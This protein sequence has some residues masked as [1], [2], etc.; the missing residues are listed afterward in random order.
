MKVMT[1]GAACS[2]CA[3]QFIK[4]L[5]AKEHTDH[6]ERAVESILKHHYVDNFVD[7]F[8]NK[9]EAIEVAQQV[10]EIH[11][12][13]G[14][15]LRNLA[16]NSE[17][18][19][20][21]LCG[22]DA[23]VPILSVLGTRLMQTL[24]EEHS[25]KASNCIL[26]SDSKTVVKWMRIE[27]RRYKPFVAHRVAEILA[28]TTPSNWR[29]VPTKEN[30]ADE[31]T[32]P[33]GPHEYTAALRGLCGPKS[34][35]RDEALW[36]QE[37]VI[38][39]QHLKE[40]EELNPRYSLVIMSIDINRFSS[41]N[42]LRRTVAWALRFGLTSLKLDSA[43]KL[44]LR[45]TQQE[46]FQ[47][48]LQNIAKGIPISRTS[49]LYQLSL[50][51]DKDGV[52]RVQGRIDAASSLPFETRHP[53]ILPSRHALTKLL[54]AYH[55]NSF[56]HENTE[57]TICEI[58]HSYWIPSLCQLLRNIIANSFVCRI[59]KATPA[60]PLDR[61]D[62][63]VRPFTY[64][65]LDYFG[66]VAVTIGRRHEKRWV[67]LFTC[68]TVRAVHLE[69]AHDLSTDSCIIAI[70]NFINRRGVPAKIRSDNGKNFVGANEEAKRFAEV[71]DCEQIQVLV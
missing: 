31:A 52:L 1:F 6:A 47:L 53:I 39:D 42:R 41:F 36:S 40:D 48:E 62:P 66:P 68:L 61:L 44:L 37:E 24:Q 33:N 64:S 2:P 57:A 71:F 70:R 50:Y 69:L 16:S 27:H 56:K 21:A 34:L 63:F 3:A 12:R 8:G 22:V 51:T 46:A 25:V 60:A 5:N 67:A 23:T 9:M 43:K 28:A 15:E 55:H 7:S 65:G 35:L 13:A 49:D 14:F 45:H 29:W 19:V 58:R 10:R 54:V 20:A 38:S 17:E 30:S 4:T 32:R 59:Q 26:W 18:V 11:Q